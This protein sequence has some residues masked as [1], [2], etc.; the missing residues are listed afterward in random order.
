MGVLRIHDGLVDILDERQLI[1]VAGYEPL[2][3]DTDE[4]SVSLPLSK[5]EEQPSP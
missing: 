2:Y 3:L 4:L 1:D 5:P